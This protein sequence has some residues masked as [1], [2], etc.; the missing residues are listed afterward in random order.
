MDPDVAGPLIEAE[1]RIWHT[2]MVE[3]RRLQKNTLL[4][5]D[6]LDTIRNKA[7]VIRGGS[8]ATAQSPELFSEGR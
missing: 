5:A 7:G 4:G 1:V 3:T 2:R 8:R 6:H